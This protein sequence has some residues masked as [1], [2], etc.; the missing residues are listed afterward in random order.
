VDEQT[1]G[2]Q[3]KTMKETDQQKNKKRNTV[4]LMTG[5]AVLCVVSAIA[6]MRY[7]AQQRYSSAAFLMSTVLEQKAYGPHAEDAMAQVETTLAEMENEQSLYIDDSDIARLNAAAGKEPVQVSDRTYALL[8][9]AKNLGLASDG[10]FDITIA[11]LSL[12]W[13]VTT[14][15]PHVLTQEEIDALLPLVDQNKLILKNGTAYLEEA[16]MAVD[17]GGIA[18]GAACDLAVE[19]YKQNNVSSALVNFG[20][21][22]IYALGTKPDGSLYKLGFRDPTKDASTSIASFTI[23]E[24][25]FATSGGYERYFEEDGVR[26]HH[27][28]DPQTGRPAD[29]DIVSVGVFCSTGTEA[30]FYSTCLFVWG[31]EKT[32]EYMKNGGNVIFLDEENNLYVSQMFEDSFQ[33]LEDGYN[34]IF[35]APDNTEAVEG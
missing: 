6:L 17:L 30:D 9:A 8:Q 5:L 20:G 13:G 14:D 3:E 18:K 22:T 29:S 34:V 21:S 23:P 28:L 16:G 7:Q 19:I 12:A 31:K 15:H 4:L 35:V 27:I 24:G 2:T 1:N 10:A 33:L 25:S 32:L 26:Y 11:P